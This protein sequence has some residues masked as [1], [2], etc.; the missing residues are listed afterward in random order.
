MNYAERLEQLIDDSLNYDGVAL[1]LVMELLN[2]SELSDGQVLEQIELI[3][4]AWRS[5]GVK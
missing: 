2:G 3:V 4:S 1:D 5:K